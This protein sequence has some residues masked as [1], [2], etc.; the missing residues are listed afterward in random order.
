MKWPQYLDLW[1]HCTSC[2]SVMRVIVLILYLVLS[3]FGRYGT[4]S[5]SSLISLEI[6]ALDLSASKWDHRSPVSWS[7]TS[8]TECHTVLVGLRVV[9]GFL[10][11][12]FDLDM[13][14][15]SRLRVRH[16]TDRQI[17]GQ[18][19]DTSISIS[20]Y[21]YKNQFTYHNCTKYMLH[22]RHNEWH[23]YKS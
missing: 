3:A 22:K 18:T 16:R 4:F 21:S 11:A 15:H 23:T 5:V 10:P 20:S 2:M 14:F 6:L 13:P 12:N 9:D 17:D 8:G 19:D 7:S 1:R